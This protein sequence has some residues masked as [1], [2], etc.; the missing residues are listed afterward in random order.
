M[1]DLGEGGVVFVELELGKGALEVRSGRV[2]D[3]Q[4]EWK[5][6]DILL[7][8][9]DLWQCGQSRRRSGLAPGNVAH[10]AAQRAL[11]AAVGAGGLFFG[12]VA[13][14]EELVRHRHQVAA[15]SSLSM[16]PEGI[17]AQLNFTN[18]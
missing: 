11:E 13:E 2:M 3:W 8:R 4:W 6:T 16:R 17:A 14:L 12:D 1:A 5:C 10:R 15:K 7:Y 9:T 18:V